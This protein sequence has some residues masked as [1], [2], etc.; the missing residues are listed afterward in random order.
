MVING[1]TASHL[2][3]LSV[4]I[5]RENEDLGVTAIAYN[6]C[7]TAIIAPRSSVEIYTRRD[8][9]YHVSHRNFERGSRA[10]SSARECGVCGAG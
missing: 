3:A 10:H 4:Q 8:I 5:S 2:Q 7:I 1:K 6:T 9:W